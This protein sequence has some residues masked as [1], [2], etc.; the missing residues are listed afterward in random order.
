MPNQE[1]S[2][3]IAI[4]GGGLAGVLAASRLRSSFEGTV[5][6]VEANPTLGGRSRCNS[7]ETKQWPPSAGFMSEK[8]YS[9]ISNPYIYIW[10]PCN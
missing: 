10:V 1:S 3:D 6:L 7:W 2:Y 4:I 9:F 8:L 5:L